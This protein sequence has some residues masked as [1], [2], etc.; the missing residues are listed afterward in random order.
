MTILTNHTCFRQYRVYHFLK[1]LGHNLMERKACLKS[2]FKHFCSLHWIAVL[3]IIRKIAVQKV[4]CLL[5][6]WTGCFFS[7]LFFLDCKGISREA[8]CGFIF[9]ASSKWGHLLKKKKS[10]DPKCP[11]SYVKKKW[12]KKQQ[13]TAKKMQ[14]IFFFYQT[15]EHPFAFHATLRRFPILYIYI[16]SGWQI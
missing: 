13:K 3:N 12:K 2:S 14:V 9:Y 1:Y 6:P 8:K 15:A 7:F 4:K 10:L 11:V 5:C 16:R